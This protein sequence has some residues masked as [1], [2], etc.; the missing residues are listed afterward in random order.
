VPEHCGGTVVMFTTEDDKD[1]I[2]R[3]CGPSTPKGKPP[4]QAYR[5]LLGSVPNGRFTI[6]EKDAKGNY[7]RLAWEEI[8]SLL[9]PVRRLEA[10]HCRHAQCRHDG[11]ENDATVIGELCS[12][13]FRHLRGQGRG[14]GCLRITSRSQ[15]RASRCRLTTPIGDPRLHGR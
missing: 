2:H 6:C 9:S 1:E 12:A 5:L 4:Q 10:R 14:Y 15:A 11:S 8:V 13:L 3:A 7:R